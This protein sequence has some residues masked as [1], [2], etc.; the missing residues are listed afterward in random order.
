MIMIYLILIANP[1]SYLVIHNIIILF[2]VVNDT[3]A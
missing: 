1:V 3:I 2:C